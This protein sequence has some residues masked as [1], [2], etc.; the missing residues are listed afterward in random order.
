MSQRR[1]L[2][3]LGHKSPMQTGLYALLR[4]GGILQNIKHP[5]SLAAL[6]MRRA[7]IS[8]APYPTLY[9]VR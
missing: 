3:R 2:E 4:G 6:I 1:L 5:M 8:Q 9:F 7:G